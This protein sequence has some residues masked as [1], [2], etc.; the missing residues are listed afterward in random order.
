MI[1]LSVPTA[2]VKLRTKINTT[3]SI[4]A[5]KA[6][7]TMATRLASQWEGQGMQCE[8]PMDRLRPG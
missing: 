1:A 6:A 8:L 3:K 2:T 7:M 4:P 5:S